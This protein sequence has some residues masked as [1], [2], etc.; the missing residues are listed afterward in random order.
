[1]KLTEHFTFEELVQTSH[2]EYADENYNFGLKNKPMVQWLANHM[3][4]LRGHL[5]SPIVV[6][7][8]VRCARLNEA[9][10]GA[11]ASQHTRIEA[12][13]F[14]VPGMLIDVAFDCIR[15]YKEVPFDQ[16]ILE[17]SRGS[18]WI[19]ISFTHGEPRRKVLK[20]NDKKYT[21]VK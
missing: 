10:G 12:V 15:G 19:H 7:S 20:Y 2:R 9:V 16:L 1:M 13:D 11:K 3:E 8:G 4:N 5:G 17:E 6:A 14:I 18:K 21:E